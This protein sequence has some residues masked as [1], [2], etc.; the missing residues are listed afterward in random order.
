MSNLFSSIPARKRKR[1]RF[2]LNHQYNT[3]LGFGKLVPVLCE[4]VIPGDVWNINTNILCR[5]APMLAPVMHDVDIR[6][7]CFFVPRRLIVGE[8]NNEIF[9]SGGKNGQELAL[10]PTIRPR[11]VHNFDQALGLSMESSLWDYLKLPI[12]PIGLEGFSMFTE[13]QAISLLPFL[14]VQLIYQEYYRDQNLEDPALEFPFVDTGDVTDIDKIVAA[15]TLRSRKYE[16]DY[17]TGAL[18]FLQRGPQS[19]I[20]LGGEADIVYDSPDST[21]PNSQQRWRD[22]YGLPVGLGGSINPVEFRGVA[23]SPGSADDITVMRPSGSVIHAN[24]DP[25]GTLKADLSSAT[26]VSINDLR[27]ASALQRLLEGFARGGSRY[28]E[29]ILAQFGVISSDTR[30]HRPEYLSGGRTPAMF[31]P[32]IQQSATESSTPLGEMAGFG[33]GAGKNHGCLRHFQEHGYIIMFVSVIPRTSYMQGVSRKFTRKDRFDYAWPEMAHLGEQ[34]VMLSELY[35]TSNIDPE[36]IFGYVP[37]YAEYKY[38]P[39]A[40]TGAFRNSLDFWNLARKFE[41][42]PV[43]S[44]EFVTVRSEDASRIFAT[45]DSAL[46]EQVYINC[47]HNIM[48]T[49]KL[50][51]Y[52]LPGLS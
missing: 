12:S 19:V 50:P 30:M 48:C 37:R 29:T 22:E 4:E 49:R 33:L 16:K 52:G 41:N 11:Y 18:P 14:A 23:N 34:P 26:A 21:D 40:T 15:L 3:S 27:Y 45:A 17:F 35:Q 10:E 7:E 47:Y 13:E 5:F 32:V 46:N 25:N 8:K 38:I 28:I 1:S 20:P 24:L 39:S 6:T 43:L 42:E 2:P 36:K 44:D 31:S 51:K 9:F